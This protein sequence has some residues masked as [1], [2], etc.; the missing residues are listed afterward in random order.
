MEGGYGGKEQETFKKEE[1]Q[2]VRKRGLSKEVSKV[3]GRGVNWEDGWEE[4]K[5]W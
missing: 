5:N 3:M 4:R 1:N 2:S